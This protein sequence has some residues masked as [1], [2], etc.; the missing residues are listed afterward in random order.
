MKIINFNFNKKM[1]SKPV[2]IIFG[3]FEYRDLVYFENIQEILEING[4]RI[5]LFGWKLQEN[6]FNK[7]KIK[8]ITLLDDPGSIKDFKG[9]YININR[10]IN[11]WKKVLQIYSNH[12]IFKIRP[13]SRFKDLKFFT[14]R[15]KDLINQK[16][17]NIINV[18]TISPRFLN[19]VNLKNHYCDWII[20]GYTKDLKKFL[21]LNNINEKNLLNKKLIPNG[22]FM[23]VKEKQAEQVIFNYEMIRKKNKNNQFKIK[24]RTLNFFKIYS[25]KYKLNFKSNFSPFRLIS[26]NSLEC[27]LYNKNLIF[28]LR[29]YIPV[30]RIFMVFFYLFIKYIQNRGIYRIKI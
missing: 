25:I 17:I 28:F 14:K 27:F 8:N 5:H 30:L 13:D 24:I 29:I 15:L 1:I 11:H 9:R 20:C 23:Q 10:Q 21:S 4:Y 6:I 2:I 19:F 22:I 18:T 12:F 26:F 7:F 3:Y 16:D